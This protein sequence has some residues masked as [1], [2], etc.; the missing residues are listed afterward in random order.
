MFHL[1]MKYL[2]EKIDVQNLLTYVWVFKD[3]YCVSCYSNFHDLF[4]IMLDKLIS[5]LFSMASI[6][7]M[8]NHY[9]IQ[10]YLLHH[11]HR[12]VLCL[13]KIVL[14]RPTCSLI[15]KS[16]VVR[17][18][19]D[20]FSSTKSMFQSRQIWKILKRLCFVMVART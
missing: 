4:L 12:I 15:L 13:I 11:G 6:A 14:S 8:D 3:S 1:F 18:S 9:F 5:N 20:L 17:S 10:L 2:Y 7:S 19:F 16:C